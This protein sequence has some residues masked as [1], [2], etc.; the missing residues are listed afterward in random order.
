[1]ARLGIDAHIRGRP[2]VYEEEI[3]STTNLGGV[4]QFLT[5]TAT[6]EECD[7]VQRYTFVVNHRGHVGFRVPP[8]MINR[9]AMEVFS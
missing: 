9:A 7:V 3:C 1:M 8:V 6:K 2:I 4:I 5:F